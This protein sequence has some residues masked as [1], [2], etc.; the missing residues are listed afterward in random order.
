MAAAKTQT[1]SMRNDGL[2]DVD[3]YVPAFKV[4]VE[5][6]EI[7]PAVVTDVLDVKVTMDMEN[8]TSFELTLNN[9]DDEKFAFKYS[10]DTKTFTVGNRVH[11]MLGYTDKLVSMVSGQITT[12][13][14]KFPEAGSP[15]LGISG[16]DGMMLLRDRKPKA[17]DATKW[18]NMAD[19]EIVREIAKRNNLRYEATQEGEKRDI[20]VQK[21]QDDAQFVMERAKR[22]DFDCFIYTDPQSKESTLYFKRP[23]DARDGETTRV[24]TFEWG[25]SLIH[26]NPTLT[27]S[28]QVSKI[29][30]R[31]WD[32]KTKSVIVG[33]ATADDL[34]GGKKNAECGPK[35]AEEKLGGKQDVV[36]DAHVTSQ[37]E[38]KDLAVSLLRDRAYEF[39][40]GSGQVIG[41]ADMRPGD[42]VDIGGVGTR[43]SGTYYIKKV[44]HTFNTSGFMTN[45]EVRKVF[46]G[47]KKK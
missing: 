30:V 44:E 28:R 23:T 27:V 13:T 33:E 9:W 11:V 35:V 19:W 47:E 41:L 2:P 45:F 37:Q 21:N 31:G 6:K 22:I 32:P 3:Y 15:T 10:D 34:P 18:V 42:N 24:Y 8:M 39:L 26:F 29:T 1:G 25:T 7:D 20:V 43:F 4:E 12:L 38:A 36:V 14:P 46:E 17:G 16:L 5:G 40:T